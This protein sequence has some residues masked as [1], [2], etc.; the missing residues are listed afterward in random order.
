MTDPALNN[1]LA[2][3][4]AL[5]YNLFYQEVDCLPSSNSHPQTKIGT[6][7]LE[8]L[9]QV[10]ASGIFRF[11]RTHGDFVRPQRRNSFRRAK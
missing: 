3:E 1:L 9:S 11:R 2:R 10:F 8:S 4:N 7:D 5:R 6:T